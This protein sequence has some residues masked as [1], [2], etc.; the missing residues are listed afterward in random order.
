MTKRPSRDNRDLLGRESFFE[1]FDR[2]RAGFVKITESWDHR[3][4]FDE[5]VRA[6]N[7]FNG[8]FALAAELSI[9]IRGQDWRCF[10][11]VNY[12]FADAKSRER[13]AMCCEA[14]CTQHDHVVFV[15]VREFVQ[16]DQGPIPSVGEIAVR[17]YR[18][19]K[20]RLGPF[21]GPAYRSLF[22]GFQKSLPIICDGHRLLG[23]SPWAVMGG[24]NQAHPSIVQRS[25]KVGDCIAGKHQN[26]CRDWFTCADAINISA[27]LGVVFRAGRVGLT[28]AKGDDMTIQFVNQFAGPFDF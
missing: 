5:V 23:W 7:Y 22:N 9:D 12:E 16:S 17:F 15:P 25:A 11:A 20:Y 28:A 14:A 26:N 8:R 4:A 1:G 2:L 13:Y 27:L 18:I 19:P 6:K 24:P 10:V 21:D 3:L